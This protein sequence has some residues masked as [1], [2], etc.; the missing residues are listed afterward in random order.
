MPGRVNSA[1]SL[2][3]NVW[4]FYRAGKGGVEMAVT[5]SGSL[6]GALGLA[7][8]R[9]ICERAIGGWDVQ[10]RRVLV[11]VPDST[12]T[13]PLDMM[14]RV[15]YDCLQPAAGDLDFLVALGTHPAMSEEAIYDLVGISAA[16]HRE[17]YPRAR[18]FNHLWKDPE[19][20][21]EV[22][23]LDKSEIA[24]ATDGLFEMDVTITC[25]RMVMEHDLVLIVGPV[26]PH[27][28]VG[29]SG[30][31]KYL[32]PGV[33]GQ[34]IIDFFHWLGAVITLVEIIGK[35]HTPV[36]AVVDRAAS[37]LGVDRRA[38]C[39][40]V[41]NEGGERGSLA[42]LYA[43]TPEEAWSAAADLSA[44]TH[45]HYTGRRYHTVLSCAPP[46]Y[47]DLWTGGKCTYKVEP[48]VEDGGR[49]IIHAPHITEISPVHGHILETI[50]YHT[51]DFFLAQWEAYK[52]FPWGVV[53]HST[54]VK[55]AG[56]Y[57]NGV[58]TPR[59]E[60]ILA[61]GIPEEVCRK[62]NLGFM[63]HRE[64]RREDYAGREGEGVLYVPKAGEILY[65]VGKTPE[66]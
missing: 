36:R 60:V 33:A 62:V 59:M 52:T 3:R 65:R 57:E 50:G 26:F 7:E 44:G 15:L 54:H 58:E 2:V 10:G 53:A 1:F 6:D 20:L 17:R 31:N 41:R 29:F 61:T 55:G 30:G 25:N 27:E 66:D 11:I 39:L 43:G 42:G 38:L 49:V 28:V 40:V 46:M 22:G 63:D 64:I 34:E 23:T 12:R 45:V 21:V 16:E 5:G 9:D 14:F 56:T 51:R 13:C 32:F 19:S 47:D 35:K 8:V 4:A 18:F 24:A 37:L 48:V